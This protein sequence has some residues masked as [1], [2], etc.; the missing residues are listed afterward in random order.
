MVRSEKM[1]VSIRTELLESELRVPIGDLYYYGGSRKLE[2]RWANEKGEPDNDGE[3]LQVFYRGK[4]QEAIGT[5]WDF[6]D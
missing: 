3:C 6:H 2:A 1:K 4:W 5:D